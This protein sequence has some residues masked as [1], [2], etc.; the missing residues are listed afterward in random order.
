MFISGCL[1]SLFHKLPQHLLSPCLWAK[2]CPH[3]T[4]PSFR[5]CSYR[6]VGFYIKAGGLAS[7]FGVQEL[8]NR[9]TP[10]NGSRLRCRQ[11]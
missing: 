7:I 3:K 9:Y 8:S 2:P 10:L 11:T 1:L 6:G 4:A 5:G